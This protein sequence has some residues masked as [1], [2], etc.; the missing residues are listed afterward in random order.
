M[1][2]QIPNKSAIN[3]KQTCGP[4]NPK[5][6]GGNSFN[7]W[8]S[9]RK[10]HS[11]FIPGYAGANGSAFS[12]NSQSIPGMPGPYGRKTASAA[13]AI[14]QASHNNA[15]RNAKLGKNFMPRGATFSPSGGAIP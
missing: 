13:S 9:Q 12:P 2:A 7:S 5:R 14:K 1:I 3:N 6:C 11:G 15:S 10:Y 4:S 8:Y